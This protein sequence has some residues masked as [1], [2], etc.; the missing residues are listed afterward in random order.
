MF[1]HLQ[2]FFSQL[3]SPLRPVGTINASCVSQETGE[4]VETLIRASAS[5]QLLL[6]VKDRGEHCKKQTG[7]T[8]TQAFPEEWLSFCSHLTQ[9]IVSNSFELKLCR[10]SLP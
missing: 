6:S 8:G 9:P 3:L 10:Q 2:P 4:A 7:N 1:L 5:Q